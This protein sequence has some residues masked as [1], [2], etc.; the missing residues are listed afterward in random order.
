MVDVCMVGVRVNPSECWPLSLYVCDSLPH[1][2]IM[3][4]HRSRRH[5]LIAGVCGGFADQLGW[6]PARVRIVYVIGSIV[7][8]AFP[9]V[10]VYLVLWWLMP[11]AV[12]V[13]PGGA[14]SP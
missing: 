4:F 12:E 5:R 9:G 2:V 13:R 1:D 6:S 10:L 11:N 8:A 14:S 3:P 7:S